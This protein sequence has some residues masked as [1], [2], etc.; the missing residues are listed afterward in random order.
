[1]SRVLKANNIWINPQQPVM[2]L[3]S[4]ATRRSHTSKEMPVEPTLDAQAPKAVVED[5]VQAAHKEAEAILLRANNESAALIAKAQAQV[6][7][8]KHSAH[9]MGY[10]AGRGE[11]LEEALG[12]F[13]AEIE[14][15]R[16]LV[17]A[18]NLAKENLSSDMEPEMIALAFDIADKIMQA[19][20]DHSDQFLL[21]IAEKAIRQAYESDRIFLHIHPDHYGTLCA[22][23]DN[24][25]SGQQLDMELILHQNEKMK[26]GDLRLETTQ[27][28]IDVGLATQLMQIRKAVARY[29]PSEKE[30]GDDF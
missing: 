2:I 21:H 13:A 20:L 10:Q 11:G 7:Q 14:S 8:I 18:L 9:E 15:L 16:E 4:E 25:P 22:L 1:M 17:D 27:G 6:D 24:M 19:E 29:L 5:A 30:V 28:L 3:S 23:K 12:I 26:P